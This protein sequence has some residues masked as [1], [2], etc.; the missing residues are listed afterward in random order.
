MKS[1][2]FPDGAGSNKNAKR[3]IRVV[4][5]SE[6]SPSWV[7]QFSRE[8]DSI[9]SA[10]KCA[11]FYI[12]HVG[13]TAV[14]GLAG[15]PIVDILISLSDWSAAGALVAELEDLGYDINEKCDDVPRYFLTK[16]SADGCEDFHVHIC[17]P[18]CHWGARNAYFQKRAGRRR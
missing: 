13:S 5:I 3:S 15:K 12:D 10:I 8:A 9:R 18:G 14:K 16:Y 1:D 17:E 7:D 6:Y 4:N 11:K 2:N